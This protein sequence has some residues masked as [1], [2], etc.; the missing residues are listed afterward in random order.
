MDMKDE[1]P[2]GKYY[3]E[4]EY[5]PSTEGGVPSYRTSD[6]GCAAALHC[7]GF[8]PIELDR[9]DSQRVEFLFTRTRDVTSVVAAYWDNSLGVDAQSYFSSIRILKNRLYS[10]E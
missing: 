10:P 9:R 6:L 3:E 7:R 4:E 1:Y 8:S 5:E 2:E